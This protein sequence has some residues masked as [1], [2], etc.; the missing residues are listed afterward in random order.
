MQKNAFYLVVFAALLSGVSGLLIKF[1]SIP[2]T[3]M[4]AIRMTTP[5]IL[6]GVYLLYR[7]KAVFK[8]GYRIM[9]G[10]SV[11][12]TV[13][14]FFFFMA[15][16]YTSIS[17]AIITLYTWPIFATILSVILLKESIS[18]RQIALLGLSFV[19]I[20]IVYIGHDFS[21]SDKDFI[22]LSS[23]VF[24]AFFYACSVIIFKSKSA[25]FDPPETIFFQ[26]L[27]GAFVF[28]PFLFFNVPTPTS[29]DWTLGLTHG[30][31]IGV[32]MFSAF[33]YGLKYI[34]A[35]KASMITYVEVISAM[36]LG[37]FVL[38]EKLTINMILGAAII[39]TSTLLLRKKQGQ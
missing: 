19:G 9:L 5:T 18:K 37:Y 16:I 23:G 39:L 20:L 8:P 33:F 29:L 25:S 12:N 11:V 34:D 35:S 21:F 30:I 26:N 31:L 1:M 14:M 2:A 28:L 38:D 22:G 32:I 15:Y 13:R 27:L 10:A 4:A 3:S 24:G 36:S 6:V 17:N 7:Q